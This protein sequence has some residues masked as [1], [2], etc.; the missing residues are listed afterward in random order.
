[1]IFQLRAIWALIYMRNWAGTAWKE[2]ILEVL[3]HLQVIR[4]DKWSQ[5]PNILPVSIMFHDLLYS[6]RFFHI[7]SCSSSVFLQLSSQSYNL[8]ISSMAYS[9]TYSATL[10]RNLIKDFP[11]AMP[12]ESVSWLNCGILLD[13]EI[14]HFFAFPCKSQCIGC[15]HQ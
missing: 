7:L 13:I 6:S 11:W 3:R 12:L 15:N 9:N 2:T 5:R 14:N 8:P 1:M 10:T 4:A